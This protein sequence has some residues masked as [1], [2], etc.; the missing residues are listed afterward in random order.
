MKY[1]V[2]DAVIF[3]TLIWTVMGHGAMVSPLSRNAIDR[4]LPWEE[5]TPPEPC[6]CA[7]STAGSAGPQSKVI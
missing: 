2:V 4:S 5:R 3:A 7:N 1:I 6:T